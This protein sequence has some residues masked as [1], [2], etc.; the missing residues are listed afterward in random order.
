ME[1]VFFNIL[2]SDAVD[3]IDCT[4]I[5][6]AD[7]ILLHYLDTHRSKAPDGIH[8]REQK[9]LAQVSAKP[10]SIT[11]Q[12]SQLSGEVPDDYRLPK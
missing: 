5:K 11:Y 8:I 2:M 9:E 4:P 12:Q 10:L 7:D 1:P 6:F 3:R